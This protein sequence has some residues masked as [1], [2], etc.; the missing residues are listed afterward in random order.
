MST[1]KTANKSIFVSSTF[2]DMQAE[3][4][5]L[6]DYVVPRVNEFAFKYNRAVE[7]ID[8]R[9]GV[10][11]ASVS[12]EEQ[13]KKV[14]RTCLDEI[15]RSRPFFIGLIGDRYGWTP[16]RMEMEAA[17]NDASIFLDDLNMSVTALEIEYGVL[18]SE[19]TP[20]SLFYFRK[21]PD[22]SNISKELCSIYQDET[23]NLERLRKLKE[24]IRSRFK[25]DVK[26]YNVELNETG[27]T[28]SKEWAEMIA[29]DIMEKLRI[30]WGEPSDTP[31]SWQE[32]ERE[33][34]EAFRK[35]RT[36][37]FAGRDAAITDLSAFCL[38]NESTPQLLMIKGESG[39]G[40]SGLLCKV[41]DRVDNKCLLLPFSCGISSHSS[42]VENMLRYFIS[43]ICE[44]MLLEN[45]SDTIT[46]FQDLKER[47]I[48]L[49]FAAS[50]KMQIV[51]V[52]DALDQFAGGD[53]A[54]RI[55]WITGRLPAN[56]RLLCSIIEGPEIDA[57][58]Q[59]GG[60]IRSMP[61]ISK[62]DEAA[63]IHGIAKRHHKQINNTVAEFIL[64]KK[65]SE[66]VES[67]QNP[68]YLSLIT[69]DLV[70]MDRYELDIV[71]KYIESGMSH[72]DALTKFMQQRIDETPG[73][74]EGAYQA[75]LKRMEKLIGRDFVR[76]VCG[77]IA[78]SRSGLRESDL[79]GAFKNLGMTFNPADFSWLRQMLRGHMSQGDMQQWDFSHQSLRRMLRNNR[80]EE[81]KRFNDGLF[82]H[83]RNVMEYDNFASREIMHHLCVANRPDLAV[84]VMA[85]Y[86]GTHKNTLIRGLAEIY[87]EHKDGDKFLMLI[88]ASINN[89]EGTNL[90]LISSL[91]F[92]CLL[93]MPENT[94][95][96]RIEVM[97]KAFYMLEGQEDASSLW[98][99]SYCGN[100][101]AFYLI[102]IGQ[103]A[104]AGEYYKKVLE[105]NKT[106][107]EKSRTT[108][109][110]RTMLLSYDMMGDY[111][112]SLGKTKE[113]GEYYQKVMDEQKQLSMQ[114]VSGGDTLDPIT[115]ARELSAAS[116]KMGGYLQKLGKMDE[117][118]EYFNIY[119]DTQEQIYE[120]C[121]TI[122]ALND[123]S[124]SY[125][126][127][128]EYFRAIGKIEEAGKYY[129]KA[130]EAN[131]IFYEQRMT[132]D[133]LLIL[134]GSYNN[135][136]RYF[137]A[138]G[139]NEEA[140]EYFRK[141]IEAHKRLY[142][143]SKTTIAL[144]N[145]S[146][147]YGGMGQCLMELGKMEEAGEYIKKTL[148][149][150][151]MLYE[152]CGTSEVLRSLSVSYSDMGN[153]LKKC[154]KTVEAREYY[155]KFIESSKIVHDQCETSDSLRD[156][157]MSYGYMGEC[158]TVLD[159]M[160][161]AG[162]Y[163]KKSLELFKILYEQCGTADALRELSVSYYKMGNNLKAFRKMEKA[164]EYYFKAIEFSKM[165]YN[166]FGTED[167]LWRLVVSYDN[168]G[169]CKY[170]LG[171]N[172][173][174]YVLRQKAFDFF[175]QCVKLNPAR[176]KHDSYYREKAEQSKP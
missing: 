127:M 139:K 9:W 18:R 121:K 107:Y 173:E 51:A 59:L 100:V 167:A 68:L 6:R 81:L 25:T 45:D 129:Q 22:Y 73:D 105:I 163:I 19:K 99:K 155:Y 26:S 161:E 128:G 157:A 148:E 56:F 70:M 112:M 91:L 172:D 62:E 15:E 30:E 168:L 46:K 154:G 136:G 8:L 17:L 119:V 108:D 125:D 158:L 150:F 141:S 5:M 84:E 110:L 33:I 41:M 123:L 170:A 4:D 159:K 3:R 134:S 111:L 23:E 29:A 35:S 85:L 38:S 76:G 153:Y 88:P 82:V 53:E 60:E 145:L 151:N 114:L 138:H 93:L 86:G 106:L 48:E 144:S 44:K 39:S 169:D 124:K 27:I 175:Q 40:K 57:I 174:A 50:K 55:L 113:A 67:A 135:M 120:L 132:A 34:Q 36:T 156:L 1:K 103:T 12:E 171:Y 109:N 79:E 95:E 118:G 117:A 131:K 37:H 90:W 160:E 71:Q 78:V 89:V 130:L 98:G 102:E 162:E 63:I 164:E 147:L 47:F 166:Q 77:M 142:E 24:E 42:L 54:R 140:I 64:K 21:S 101:I 165:L 31:L 149:A 65:N 176:Q 97:K 116:G 152:Q 92:L 104:E 122:D 52:V 66:G 16:P 43:I 75:I 14:L 2:R 49:L 10:D 94:R 80:H 61:Q 143:Q 13:N 146:K 133:A 32:H 96:F 115:T 69:Q 74:P 83:F 28:I 58:K 11:T 20:I 137:R 7:I 126:S 72:A 87:I